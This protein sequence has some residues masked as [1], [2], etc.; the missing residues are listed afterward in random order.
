MK[1]LTLF[2]VICLFST[3]LFAKDDPKTHSSSPKVYVMMKH[4]KLIEVRNGQRK[5]VKKDMQLLNETTIH[6]DGS[7]D[8]SSGQRLQLKNGEYITLDGRI[9]KLKDM[10]HPSTKK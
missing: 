10:A 2:V 7:I 1:K 4:G 9:R 3:V 8:A 6:P 5:F